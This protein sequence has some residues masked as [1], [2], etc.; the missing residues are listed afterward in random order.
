MGRGDDAASAAAESAATYAGAALQLRTGIADVAGELAD[1]ARAA[2]HQGL[3]AE[4]GAAQRAA[5]DALLSPPADGQP[6]PPDPAA[7][8]DVVAAQAR[9]VALSVTLRAVLDRLSALRLVAS[10]GGL[11][12]TVAY[13]DATIS[14]LAPRPF[15]GYV[16]PPRPEGGNVAVMVFGVIEHHWDIRELRVSITSWANPNPKAPQ[17]NPV[18]VIEDAFRLWEVVGP[19]GQP[20]LFNFRWVDPDGTRRSRSPSATMPA[21][22]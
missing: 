12:D 6:S 1:I 16:D 22:A 15:C 4:A 19:P 10:S 18:D 13:V 8:E 14:G 11:A 20:G 2:G 3:T 21:R 9:V 7:T 17:F 5:Q